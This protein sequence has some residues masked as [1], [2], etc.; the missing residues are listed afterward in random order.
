MENT[1]YSANAKIRI[2]KYV[3]KLK[4][5]GSFRYVKG[6][7]RN[8]RTLMAILYTRRGE[9]GVKLDKATMAAFGMNTNFEGEGMIFCV[10]IPI[11]S[12]GPAIV[13]IR[14]Y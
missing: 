9:G 8:E 1:T 2:E 6:L 12:Y 7:T 14:T 10:D 3:A 4:H 11:T 5:G 13:P